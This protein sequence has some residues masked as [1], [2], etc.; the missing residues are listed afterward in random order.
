MSEF[1]QASR[2]QNRQAVIVRYCLKFGMKSD[3]HIFVFPIDKANGAILN[4]PD[5]T[6]SNMRRHVFK[7]N[8]SPSL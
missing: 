1:M 4:I 3:G 6:W 5:K 2:T 7:T 8:N